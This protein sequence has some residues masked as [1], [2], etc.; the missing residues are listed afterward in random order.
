[1][2][3][4]EQIKVLENIAS[5][6]TIK[7]KRLQQDVQRHAEKQCNGEY[8]W[9]DDDNEWQGTEAHKAQAAEQSIINRICEYCTGIVGVVTNKK[10]TDDIP[11]FITYNN[12]PRGF[13]LKIESER[14]TEEA[15]QHCHA[16]GFLMDWGG[17]Y[18]FLFTRE[19]KD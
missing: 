19:I 3:T 4:S 17:D 10:T 12:D 11:N 15:R 8:Y 18:S 14:L 2:T 9:N 13:V 7:R 5:I 1:M 6:P 16:L